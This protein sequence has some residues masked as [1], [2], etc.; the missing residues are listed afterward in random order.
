MKTLSALCAAAALCVALHV[1]AR[2]QEDVLRPSIPPPIKYG[3]EVGANYNV[4][5]QDIARS[6]PVPNSPFDAY[7]SG[8]GV[9]PYLFAYADYSVT[10]QLGIQLKAGLD[11]K[12]FGNERVGSADCYRFVDGQAEFD[13][14]SQRLSYTVASTY[15]SLG[16]MARVTLGSSFNL[17]FGPVLHVRLDSTNQVEE[18]EYITNGPCEFVDDNGTPLGKSKTEEKNIQSNPTTRLGLELAA[19]FRIPI[20]KDL[21]LIPNIRAQYMLT[22]Y[23]EDRASGDQYQRFSTGTAEVQLTQTMLHSAQLGFAVQF[24]L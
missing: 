18:M 1:P 17:S 15:I 7:A 14:L 16:T 19:G 12:V 4:F 10:K 24:G 11:R 13:T 8:D 2:A 9:S 22:E 20:G 21:E 5:S 3:V 23:I 6:H